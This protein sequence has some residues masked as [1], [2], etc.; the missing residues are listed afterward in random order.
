MPQDAAV[1]LMDADTDYII[2]LFSVTECLDNEVTF[3]PCDY[4]EMRK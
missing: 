4:N 1:N 3:F 2:E